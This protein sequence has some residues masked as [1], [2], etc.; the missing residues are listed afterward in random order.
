MKRDWDLIRELLAKVEECSLPVDSIGLSS[1]P[2]ERATE[3]AFHMEL[4]FEAGFVDGQMFRTIGPGPYDF[5][6]RRLTWN[7]NEFLD[8]I[9]NDTVWQ[10]T[11][12]VFVR[13]GISM[14]FDLIKSVATDVAGTILKAAI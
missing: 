12:K 3:I 8:R 2:A 10:K 5:S 4:L 14:T 7:G 6:A 13:E 11:K 9:R 1:F